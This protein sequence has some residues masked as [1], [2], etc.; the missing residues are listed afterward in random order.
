MKAV[1]V[2]ESVWNDLKHLQSVLKQEQEKFELEH[3]EEFEEGDKTPEVTR[4]VVI[5]DLLCDYKWHN[6][7][8]YK[9]EQE[10]NIDDNFV[11]K[12]QYH[13]LIEENREEYGQDRKTI[14]FLQQE[15]KKS[16]AVEENLNIQLQELKDI[17]MKSATIMT[18]KNKTI[19]EMKNNTELLNQSYVELCDKHN[20]LAEKYNSVI[21]EDKGLREYINKRCIEINDLH[22]FLVIC[23]VLFKHR[24]RWFTVE[25]IQ[26][27]LWR[28]TVTEISDVLKLSEFDIFPVIQGQSKRGDVFKYDP[29]YLRLPLAQVLGVQ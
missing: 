27:T 26:K 25:E 16:F 29:H 28:K 6:S 7:P 20:N 22:S 23:R 1:R 17:N 5:G 3:P 19:N 18:D 15:L 10:K 11:T 4:N 21:E 2:S 14:N 13:S 24:R 9:E 12:E 8:K